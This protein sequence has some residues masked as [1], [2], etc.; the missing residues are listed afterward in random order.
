MVWI[1]PDI[2]YKGYELHQDIDI[3]DDEKYFRFNT[4]LRK[5]IKMHPVF[6]IPTFGEKQDF[7]FKRNEFISPKSNI[8]QEIKQLS[9]KSSFKNP[10]KILRDATID[11]IE[12]ENEE[13]A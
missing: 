13:I 2:N 7:Y 9:L 3:D 5:K 8:A 6:K 4:Q 11:D 1:V 12:E 10:L